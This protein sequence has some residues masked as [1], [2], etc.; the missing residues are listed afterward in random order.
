M[1]PVIQCKEKCSECTAQ[2]TIHGETGCKLV[3]AQLDAIAAEKKAYEIM[4]EAYK[5]Q[6]DYWVKKQEDDK[7]K[8]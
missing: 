1:T 7:L 3:N 5:A 8:W 6:R 4:R 2:E